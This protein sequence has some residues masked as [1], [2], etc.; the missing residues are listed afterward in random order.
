MGYQSSDLRVA[1]HMCMMCM[2]V[3]CRGIKLCGNGC[4]AKR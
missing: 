2:G 4:I 1:I 3:L